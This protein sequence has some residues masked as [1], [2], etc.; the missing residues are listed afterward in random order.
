MIYGEVE[1]KNSDKSI[2]KELDIYYCRNKT[3]VEDSLTRYG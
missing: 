2:D 3:V 1:C